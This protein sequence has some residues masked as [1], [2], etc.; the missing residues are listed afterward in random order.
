MNITQCY[1]VT[2]HVKSNHHATTRSAPGAA[3]ASN[4]IPACSNIHASILTCHRQQV[5]FTLYVV[6]FS[7]RAIVSHYLRN[8]SGRDFNPLRQCA[9]NG[10][11]HAGQRGKLWLPVP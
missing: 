2:R 9:R 11:N 1:F 7:N 5:E 3:L 10:A 6:F 8:D 4:S